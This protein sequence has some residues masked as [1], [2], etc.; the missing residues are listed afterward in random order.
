MSMGIKLN[1]LIFTT[2]YHITKI[3]KKYCFFNIF[4]AGCPRQ[5]GVKFQNI[6]NF[7]SNETL[8]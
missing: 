3:I 8:S 5:I 6:D 7:V 4:L 1:K 2:T